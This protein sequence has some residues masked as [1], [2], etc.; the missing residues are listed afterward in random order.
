MAAIALTDENGDLNWPHANSLTYDASTGKIWLSIFCLD[1]IVQIDLATGNQD[2]QMGGDASDW[3]FLGDTA[4]QHQHAPVSLDG[5]TQLLVVDNGDAVEGTIAP[6]A[7][8]VGEGVNHWF[9]ATEANRA[10][11]LPVMLTGNINGKVIFQ[12]ARH[13]VAPSTRAAS[14]MSFGIACKP[15]SNKMIINGIHTQASSAMI[16]KRAV[17]GLVKKAGLSQP[18]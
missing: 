18:M 14:W 6:A 10:A 7:I 9:H 16:Q 15:A 4:F 2:W 11:Y 3:S 1:A 13:P 5:G 12:K 17:H 8:H